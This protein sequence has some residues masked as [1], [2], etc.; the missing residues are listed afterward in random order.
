LEGENDGYKKFNVFLPAAEWTKLQNEYTTLRSTVT[1]LRELLGE[2]IKVG[3]SMR[4]DFNQFGGGGWISVWDK[5]VTRITS[6]LEKE[7]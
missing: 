4:N 6:L 2:V 5:T 1:E 7:G 3:G